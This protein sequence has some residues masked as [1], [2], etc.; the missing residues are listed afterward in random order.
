MPE[1][2]AKLGVSISTGSDH[3][4]RSDFT[5]AF[6]AFD[7]T[8]GRDH[9]WLKSLTYD[10]GNSRIVAVLTPMEADFLSARVSIAT[11]TT[12]Y[13]NAPATNTAYTLYLK[14]DG[15]LTHNNTGAEVAG[16]V[17]LWRITTGAV[18][19]TLTAVDL[20]G[21]LHGA[22]ARAVKELLD[23]HTGAAQAHGAEPG[24][25]LATTSRTD[26]N[27]SW[28]D[29]Q[30]LPTVFPPATHNH[31]ASYYTKTNLQTG[32]GALVHWNNLT[33]VPSLETPTDAQ[34]KADTATE[35]G[36]VIES[37]RP[38][39]G[40]A[41]AQVETAMGLAVEF[42]DGVTKSVR[43]NRRWP[44][45]ANLK[46]EIVAAMD[47]SFAGNV[48]M[49]VTYQVNG[50]AAVSVSVTVTTLASTTNLVTVDLGQIIASANVPAGS[51]VAFKMTR[52]GADALD[53]H[54]GKLRIY[55]TRLRKG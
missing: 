47:T 28:N 27:P 50:A 31:D 32:G 20:R 36:L 30:D 39:T 44:F 45:T 19:T 7:L 15:T 51:L 6:K 13:I 35:E 23:A 21:G 54:T 16:Q 12:Y 42:A 5:N 24:R 55:F 53:T 52:L 43:F 29:M 1:T 49:Q 48:R 9:A 33:N 22:L 41:P 4:Q 10:A 11:D 46:V 2:T 38:V 3:A 17:P 18:L 26:Q 34:T 14:S 25:K 40:E 37:A 8:V